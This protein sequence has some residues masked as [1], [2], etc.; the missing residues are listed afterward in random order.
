MG[1]TDISVEPIA[2][3]IYTGSALMPDVVVKAGSKVLVKDV[4]YT[5]LYSN[6]TNVGT[7][8]VKV[9]GKGTYEGSYTTNFKI[10][11]CAIGQAAC[12][13]IADQTYTGSA[14]KP[15]IVVKAGTKVLKKVWIIMFLIETIQM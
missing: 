13:R 7:A 12:S 1:K 10:V 3:Q 14:L 11:S 15:E 2:D 9:T 8:S 4:D 6:N 5:V